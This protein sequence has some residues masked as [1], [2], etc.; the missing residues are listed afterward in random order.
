MDSLL[1]SIVLGKDISSDS[2]EH[3]ILDLVIDRDAILRNP[4]AEVKR[5]YQRA[6]LG[7]AVKSLDHFTN[8]SVKLRLLPSATLARGRRQVPPGGG[9]D[10]SVDAPVKRLLLGNEHHRTRCFGSRLVDAEYGLSQPNIVFEDLLE[11]ARL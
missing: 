1:D 4:A 9:A 2:R 10:S 3:T 6:V 11:I 7:G 5:C 8:K